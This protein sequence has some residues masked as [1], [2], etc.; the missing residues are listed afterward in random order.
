MAD[1]AAF[2]LQVTN[3]FWVIFNV[4]SALLAL[5]ALVHCAVAK[6][7]AFEAIGTLSKGT[8]V[9]ILALAVV[10]TSILTQI[11][12]MGIIALCASLIYLLDVR[13]GIKDIGA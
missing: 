11:P 13:K 2:A 10:F 1:S 3:W 12:F 7:A 6:A 4:G 5:I 9:G 8:W